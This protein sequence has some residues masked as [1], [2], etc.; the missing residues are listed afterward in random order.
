MYNYTNTALAIF[1]RVGLLTE[2]EGEKLS[3]EMASKIHP[4]TYKEA[5]AMIDKLEM[6]WELKQ[7]IATVKSK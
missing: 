2:E 3:K 7:K 1:T 6:D 4:A 5:L